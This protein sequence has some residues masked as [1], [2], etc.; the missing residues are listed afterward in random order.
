MT[1]IEFGNFL[2]LVTITIGI[3]ITRMFDGL[4]R[5]FR[6]R[7][8]GLD[9]VYMMWF[10]IVFILNVEFIWNMR[11]QTEIQL[12]LLRLLVYMLGPILLFLSSDFFTLKIDESFDG[13]LFDYFIENRRILFG[14]LSLYM[15]SQVIVS[16]FIK[17]ESLAF[18]QNY[19]RLAGVIVA[20]VG[21]FSKSRITHIAISVIALIT[22]LFYVV[23]TDL[24][25]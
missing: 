11:L 19:F 25:M 22:L 1:A 24:M 6:K 14:A 3:G 12:S 13:T 18:L 8:I 5:L 23:S 15:V 9:I 16:V 10:L 7:D 2:V 17:A 20:L 4:A 21:F